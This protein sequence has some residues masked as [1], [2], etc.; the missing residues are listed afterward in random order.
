MK[1]EAGWTE[2]HEQKLQTMQD[3]FNATRDAI[4]FM[5]AAQEVKVSPEA[6]QERVNKE[7]VRQDRIMTRI[8]DYAKVNGGTVKVGKQE[9]GIFGVTAYNWSVTMRLTNGERLVFHFARCY[10]PEVYNVPLSHQWQYLS[11]NRRCHVPRNDN[12]YHDCES[13]P[14]FKAYIK[15]ALKWLLEETGAKIELKK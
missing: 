5:R 11:G 9:D 10:E 13:V 2:E 12:G 1:T 4:V 14:E 7:K 3:L 8:C 15:D 6:F